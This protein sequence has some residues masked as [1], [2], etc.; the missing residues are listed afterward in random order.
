MSD[1]IDYEVRAVT[2]NYAYSMYEESMT[3]RCDIIIC[4]TNLNRTSHI[5]I[6][7]SV[8]DPEVMSD[9]VSI[10]NENSDYTDKKIA[11]MISKY[12]NE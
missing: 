6:T 1:I 8:N 11:D 12:L 4:T 10:I 3:G 5:M 7:P 2:K 9:I